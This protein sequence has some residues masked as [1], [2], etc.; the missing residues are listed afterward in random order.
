MQG[1]E[2][3][4]GYNLPPPAALNNA[5]SPHI[6]KVSPNV[7]PQFSQGYLPYIIKL[8]LRTTYIFILNESNVQW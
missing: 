7:R 8:L 1:D 6:S 3:H 2:K 4:A 5:A